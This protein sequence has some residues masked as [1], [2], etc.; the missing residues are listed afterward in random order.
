MT[1][2]RRLALLGG[3]FDPPHLGH[4]HLAYQAL[5]QLGC[6]EVWFI[7][8]HQQPL[9]GASA[10]TAPS[11]RLAMVR[12]MVEGLPGMRVEP[13][14]TERG[15]LSFAVDTVRAIRAAEPGA[16]LCFLL[17]GDAARTLHRWR[18]PA[19]LATMARL[20]VCTRGETIGA[21]PDGTPPVERFA[22]RRLDVSA[23]EVRAR[24][25]AGLPVRGWVTDAVADYIAACGL[26]RVGGEAP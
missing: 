22:T 10:L 21:L 20:V 12:L 16:E 26:Y 11:H 1:A 14:E 19:A 3:S 6:D 7:P 15:G 13:I 23:T 2:P 17:G 8:A 9:K 4:L 5:E 18:E 25:R 24:V